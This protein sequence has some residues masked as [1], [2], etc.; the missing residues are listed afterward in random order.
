MCDTYGNTY[1][2][3]SP[4]YALVEVVVTNPDASLRYVGGEGSLKIQHTQHGRHSA[5]LRF[6]QTLWLG[7]SIDYMVLSSN[8]SSA[9]YS[10][11]YGPGLGVLGQDKHPFIYAGLNYTFWMHLRDAWN[12]T[13]NPPR[14]QLNSGEDEWV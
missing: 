2:D 8:V 10:Y 5:R 9:Y 6:N 7:K 13:Q 14:A 11:V 3:G 1:A 12:N 4:I